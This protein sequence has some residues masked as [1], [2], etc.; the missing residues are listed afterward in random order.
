MK[1]NLF[2]NR[3]RYICDQYLHLYL[4]YISWIHFFH[5][6]T[7][8]NLAESINH[9]FVSLKSKFY[10]CS[11]RRKLFHYSNVKRTNALFKRGQSRKLFIFNPEPR[12]ISSGCIIVC[13]RLTVCVLQLG[14]GVTS[15]KNGP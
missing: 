8:F 6:S 9:L 2:T 15:K 1:L 5:V 3:D 7:L 13:F 10:V 14:R 4:E 12:H 11:S